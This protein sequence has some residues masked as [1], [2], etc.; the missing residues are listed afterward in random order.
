MDLQAL[1]SLLR[2]FQ[3]PGLS[4]DIKIEPITAGLIND[5]FAVGGAYILQRLHGGIFRPEVNLDIAALTPPLRR[6]G[7]PV[8]TLL[9]ADTGQPWIEVEGGALEGCWRMMERLPGRTEHRVRSL[10]M[11][12]EAA[13]TLARFHQALAPV[14][15]RFH[16]SRPG[17]HDTPAHMR[18]LA[19][20][21]EQH[22]GHRLRPQVEA[23]AAELDA[24]WRSW[25]EIPALPLRIVHGDPKISNLL[26]DEQDQ[27]SGV[28]D[29][30]TMAWETLQVE[31]GDACRSWCNRGDEDSGEPVFDAA[32]F[33]AVAQGYLE[34][35]RGWIR[36]EEVDALPGA[37]ARICLELSARFAADALHESYFGWDPGIAP[38]RGEHNLLRA[39]GQLSLGRSALRQQA[40]L[41]EICGRYR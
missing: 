8:P 11:A 13:A 22:P 5:T 10:R 26:F 37:P 12:R 27:V 2:R 16:F 9:L 34:Q 35:A 41:E 18:R 4:A 40:R 23:L 39:R 25:G 29:L 15:H 28:V 14:E 24:L 33:E 36:P 31:L 30:D 38:T 20:A 3:A 17:A 21:L 7:L 6:A 32:R 19:Q 1:S